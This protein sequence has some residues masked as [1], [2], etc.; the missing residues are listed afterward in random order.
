MTAA[1]R[2]AGSLFYRA[3]LNHLLW[4]TIGSVAGSVTAFIALIPWIVGA[5]L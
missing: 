2:K 1:I 4:F 3:Y 5:G